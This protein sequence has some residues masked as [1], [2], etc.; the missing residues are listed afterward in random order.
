[1][2]IRLTTILLP[3]NLERATVTPIDIPMKRLIRVAV[4]EIWSERR[5]IPMT[6]GSKVA[7][8]QKA[9]LIPSRM[10]STNTP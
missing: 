4:P 6:S 10:S 5:V 8:N 1:V 7:N 2:L 9:L 3:V